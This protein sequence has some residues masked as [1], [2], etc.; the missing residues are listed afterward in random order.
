MKEAKPY[1]AT[2]AKPLLFGV[3]KRPTDITDAASK[4]MPRRTSF[5]I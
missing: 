3:F 4:K 1:P 5:H 2:R